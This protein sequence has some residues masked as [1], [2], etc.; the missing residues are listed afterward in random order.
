MFSLDLGYFFLLPPTPDGSAKPDNPVIPEPEGIGYSLAEAVAY[1]YDVD[2]GNPDIGNTMF[3]GIVIDG[4][5]G[6]SRS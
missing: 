3:E 6:S 1:G 5:E 4:K 2:K